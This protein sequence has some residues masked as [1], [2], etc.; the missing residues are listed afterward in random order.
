MSFV[1]VLTLENRF[2][3]FT[4]CMPFATHAEAAW[5]ARIIVP[6]IEAQQRTRVT[7]WTVERSDAPARFYRDESD[8]PMPIRLRERRNHA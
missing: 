7:S 4:S 1:A 5:W 8:V 3:P 2:E 6:R